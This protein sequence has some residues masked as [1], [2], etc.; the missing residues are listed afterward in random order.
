MADHSLP[1]CDPNRV[2][3][4][5]IADLLLCA[6]DKEAKILSAPRFPLIGM[7]WNERPHSTDYV[8]WRATQGMPFAKEDVPLPV[9]EFMFG[10]A[11]TAGAVF[12]WRF[13]PHRLGMT[14]TVKTGGLL[15]VI[16]RPMSP[17]NDKE[18]CSYESYNDFSG[19]GLLDSFCDTDP[20][21]PAWFP[22][23]VYLDATSEM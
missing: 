18:D 9:A 20:S 14:L 11:A 2:K 6:A 5:T 23:T 12:W 7:G 17:F 4:G 13:P 10:G 21:H 8:A 16:G 22:E 15:L 1:I 19:H 3:E